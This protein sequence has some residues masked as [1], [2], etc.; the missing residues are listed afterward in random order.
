MKIT[1]Y[2]TRGEHAN[3]YTINALLIRD[4]P[5]NLGMDHL[6]SRGALWVF[7]SKKN[8]LIPNVAEKIF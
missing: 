6:T 5:F 3:H 2:H 1:N 8:I 7:F 4:R